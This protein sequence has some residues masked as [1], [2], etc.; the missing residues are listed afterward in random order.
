MTSAFS[1]RYGGSSVHLGSYG[2]GAVTGVVGERPAGTAVAVACRG[3]GGASLNPVLS[4]GSMPLA[5]ALLHEEHHGQPEPRFPL[6]V[7]FCPQCSLV[8][9]TQTVPPADLFREYPYFSSFSDTAVENARRIVERIIDTRS[10]GPASLAAEIA[11]NDG[12]LLQHYAARGVRVL[13]IE[14]ARNVAA[15]AEQRGIR[16]LTEFFGREL[17]AQLTGDGIRA[18]VLHANNV[19]A[20]VP[21]LPGVVAGMQTFLG[22][23][24]FAIIEMPYVRDMLDNVEFDTIYHEHLCYFSLTALNHL[25]TAHDLTIV[26]VERLPIHGG[27]L[28]LFVEQRASATSPSA[29]VTDL[30]AREQVDGLADGQAYAQFAGRVQQLAVQLRSLLHGLKAKGHRMA[31][32]G[33]SA[34]GTTLLNYCGIGADVLDFVVDRSTV[35]QGLF[36]PGTHIRIDAPQRLLE[37]R[38]DYV[39]LLTWN[40]ADEILAQQE[41]YRRR[42]GR[43][44]VPVPEPRII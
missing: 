4:L 9:I 25:F 42:G 8:Q 35:K 34:K 23:N 6:D 31:A 26:D 29:T 21:D 24:G 11:S 22:R 2:D 16:T 36:T 38:P 40:F 28:R 17:A 37:D 5:N 1:K 13:G 3:C 15:V 39:L 27:S 41:E 30:L 7:V 19:L 20:H 33:A 43:F 10:L 12:Y 14:P 44:I 32:Y 18:D